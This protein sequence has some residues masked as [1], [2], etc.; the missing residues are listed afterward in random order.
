MYKKP[1]PSNGVK[2]K[3]KTPLKAT[4]NKPGGVTRKPGKQ[5]PK[6]PRPAG[7]YYR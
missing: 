7:G 6:T 5:L 4:P 1:M 2:K 3:M